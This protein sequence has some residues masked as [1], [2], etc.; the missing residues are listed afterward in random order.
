MKLMQISICPSRFV[1]PSHISTRGTI[2]THALVE[3]PCSVNPAFIGRYFY[4]Q[5]VI[6]AVRCD[7]ILRQRRQKLECSLQNNKMR[8]CSLHM[9]T[10]LARLHLKHLSIRC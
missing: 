9:P 3:T 8:V 6:F 7:V 1:F 2:L 4:R 10:A 5:N